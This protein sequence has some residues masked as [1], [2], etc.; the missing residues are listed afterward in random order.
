MKALKQDQQKI[1]LLLLF[2][3]VLSRLAF[4]LRD[5]Q[6]KADIQLQ[7]SREEILKSLGK[8]EDAFEK[9]AAGEELA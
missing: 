4:A 3:T 5:A 2:V 8:L 1:L 9:P 7:A 6:F